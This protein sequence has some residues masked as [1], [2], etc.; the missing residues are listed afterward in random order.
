MKYRLV[1]THRAIKDIERLDP[2]IKRRIGR[3]LL[4]YKEDLLKYAERLTGSRLGT[5]RFRIGDYQDWRL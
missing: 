2:N 3:T 4:R 1:Y 5:Y